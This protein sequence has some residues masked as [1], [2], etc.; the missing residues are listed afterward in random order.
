MME[1]AP[2]N[3]T[4]FRLSNIRELATEA[5][6]IADESLTLEDVASALTKLSRAVRW[7]AYEVTDIHDAT[8]SHDRA[9]RAAFD[10]IGP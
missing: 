4:S 5:E 3:N 8:K 9:L 7:L 6:R 1:A 10:A 2:G